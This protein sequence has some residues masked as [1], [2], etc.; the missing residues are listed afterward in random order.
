MTRAKRPRND[1]P[2][3]SRQK[4]VSS[5]HLMSPQSAELSEFEYGLIVSS[6][7]FSRWVVHCMSAAGLRELTPLDVLVLHHVNHRARDKRLTDICFI[8]NVEDTHLINYSLKKLQ[9]LGVVQ[10][11]RN[12]KDVTYAATDLGRS[13]IERYRQIRESCLISA[14]MADGTL[15]HQIGDLA[16]LLRVL[17]GCT[18]RPHAPLL[19]SDRVRTRPLAMIAG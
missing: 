19:R 8:M 7:A 9:A 4:I 17:S 6:N 13:H 1:E 16:V 15:N 5:A 2:N 11:S 14:L 18:T 10:S 12:G 3:S